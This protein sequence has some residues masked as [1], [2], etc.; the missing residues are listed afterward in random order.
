LA[1]S[2]PKTPGAVVLYRTNRGWRKRIVLNP[3]ERPLKI[4]DEVFVDEFDCG[5]AVALAPRKA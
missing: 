2:D 5:A 4:G 3:E 1:V